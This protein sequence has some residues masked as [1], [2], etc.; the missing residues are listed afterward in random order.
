MKKYRCKYHYE[1][2]IHVTVQAENPQAAHVAGLE[3]ADESINSAL[4]LVDWSEREIAE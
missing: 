2:I 4:S 1:A 3:E